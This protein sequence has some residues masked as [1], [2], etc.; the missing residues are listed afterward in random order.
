MAG[1]GE[2][3]DLPRTTGTQGQWCWET[4]ARERRKG[5]VEAGTGSHGAPEQT[6][7]EEV[8]SVFLSQGEGPGTSAEKPTT[9]AGGPGQGEGRDR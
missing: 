8:G 5:H 3:K 4:Q 2:G 1:G 7:E 6:E 9:A